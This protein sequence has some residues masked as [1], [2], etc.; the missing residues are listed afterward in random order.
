MFRQDPTDRWAVKFCQAMD[1]EP[2]REDVEVSVSF[3]ELYKDRLKR[4]P[5]NCSRD[6]WEIWEMVWISIGELGN[7]SIGW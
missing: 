1:G 5:V 2:E 3:Y 6:M 7:L 4:L